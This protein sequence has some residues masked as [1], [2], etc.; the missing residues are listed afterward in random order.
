MVYHQ[1][2]PVAT[3]QRCHLVNFCNSGSVSSTKPSHCPIDTP[4]TDKT[5]IKIFPVKRQ[6]NVVVTTYFSNKFFYNKLT[7]TNQRSHCS[8]NFA[9][10]LV[11]SSKLLANFTCIHSYICFARKAFSPILSLTPYEKG[12]QNS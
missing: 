2:L 8:L 12:R 9:E 7:I 4:A 6:K 5:V 3:F 10:R 1:V 11:I